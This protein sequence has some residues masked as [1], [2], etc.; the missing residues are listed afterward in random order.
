MLS[1]LPNAKKTLG[2]HWLTDKAALE[3]IAEA[4]HVQKGDVVLEIGPGTGTLTDVLLALGA[5]VIALEI[6]P[7]RV[8]Q[9]REKYQNLPSSRV[10]IQEGDI[11][12]YDLG[13]MPDAYKVVA[14][15]PYYLSSYLFRL[16][17]DGEHKPETAALLVQKEV[18]ERVVAK[19]GNTSA[20]SISVQFYY[21]A[22]L[23]D[24]VPAH[25]F[26]P[27]PKVDS[28]V[29]TLKRREAPLFNVDTTVFFKLI[30]AG[31]SERRK[32]LRSSLSGGLGIPKDEVE[33]LL[34]AAG[35]S[36]DARA[37][38]LSLSDWNSLYKSFTS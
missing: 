14:N 37:Q 10:F 15:I 22:S 13:N 16:L 17:T 11:R 6:D 7:I 12:T 8:K 25:L 32:K 35:V 34:T 23:G 30:K 1:D 28:Q 36:P 2:Q 24:I 26:T 20:L 18:A 9:L 3:S 19:P 21:E 5:E 38:E 4:A 27:P 33:K 29:L 31:F